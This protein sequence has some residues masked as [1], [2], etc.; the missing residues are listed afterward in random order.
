MK[1]SRGIRVSDL[2][3]CNAIVR[4]IVRPFSPNDYT[5]AMHK[6]LEWK[7]GSQEEMF[8]VLFCWDCCLATFGRMFSFGI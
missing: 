8:P 4:A 5:H 3:L 2:F 1:N 6:R 7:V